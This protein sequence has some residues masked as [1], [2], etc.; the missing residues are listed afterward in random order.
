MRFP[1]AKMA[2]E[3]SRIKY[4][5]LRNEARI[6]IDAWSPAVGAKGALQSSWF[7]VSNIPDDQR[8]IRTLAKI[9]GLVGKVLEIDEVTRFRYDYVRMRIACRDVSRVPNC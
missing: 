5:T 8:S 9:G 2:S 7:R 4:L 3:W 1:T 6:M